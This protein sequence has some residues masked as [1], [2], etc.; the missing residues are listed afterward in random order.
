MNQ[1]KHSNLN[2]AD[3]FRIKNTKVIFGFILLCAI[4]SGLYAQ[5]D[6]HTQSDNSGLNESPLPLK[7][8]VILSSGLAYH[9]R[10]GTLAGHASF[11][12]PFRLDALNDVLKTIVINDPASAHPSITYQSG[13]TLFQ[14]LRGLSVDLSDDPSMSR[15]L[16]RL[17]GEE[18]EILAPSPIR[19]RIVGIEYRSSFAGTYHEFSPWLSLNTSTGIRLFN[20]REVSAVNFMNPDINRDIS[21]ALDLI[22]LS[23][24]SNIR[25]LMV[26]LPG[27]GTRE[28]SISYVVP[29]PVWKVSYRLDLG[30]DRPMFQGWAIVDNDSDMDWQDIELSLVAGRPASFIQPLYSL[31]HVWRPIVPLAIAGAAAPVTHELGWAAIRERQALTAVQPTPAARAFAQAEMMEMAMEMEMQDLQRVPMASPPAPRPNIAAGAVET[32]QGA[33]AGDQ[34]EF[35]I[36]R[37]VTLN[38][39]MSAMLPLV[40]T[41][42]DARRLLIFSGAIPAGRSV[43]PRLG[44]EITNVS[45][46]RLPAGPITVFDGGIY[47][48]S[49]LIEFWNEDERRLISFGEDLSVTGSAAET[50]TTTV[51][52]VNLSGGVMTINRRTTLNRTYTFINSGNASRE[53]LLEHPIT[54]GTTLVSPQADETTAS[55]YR[56]NVTLPANREFAVTVSEQRPVSQRVTLM[57]LSPAAFLGFTTN[58][59][60]PPNIRAALLRAIELKRAADAADT[61]VRELEA[62]LARLTADQDRV[63]RNLQAAGSQTQQGQEFLRNLVALD[64]EINALTQ[65]I[66]TARDEARVLRRNY[67]DYVRGLNL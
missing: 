33:A 42:I 18:V 3:N 2:R 34:F 63:R 50:S 64:G 8:V 21:R 62:D 36:G 24:N 60:I 44:A 22:A 23:R 15:I 66:T 1:P 7:R 12:I 49:A 31:Y 53:L 46:M 13:Q 5:S 58:Q 65:R 37:P 48:G 16:A 38:R 40:E 61:T 41:E 14:T 28:V 35:T 4:G 9:E 52:S 19:G 59:E 11:P 39:G 25:S 43:N 67:E 54:S 51:S 32:A 29:S 56:F 6:R 26:N 27:T 17:R 10:A 30:A 47:A 55:V 20:L 57:T 45:G